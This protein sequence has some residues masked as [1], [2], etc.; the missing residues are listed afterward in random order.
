MADAYT[1][2][3]GGS[4][5]LDSYDCESCGINFDTLEWSVTK[6]GVH[7]HASIGCYSSMDE[8]TRDWADVK[9]FLKHFYKHWPEARGELDE[10]KGELKAYMKANY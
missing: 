5:T 8:Y 7:V 6:D 9:T 4:V 10:F 1:P 3:P 2:E